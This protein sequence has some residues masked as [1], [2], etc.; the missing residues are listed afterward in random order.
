MNKK[1]LVR[2]ISK[3][4]SV[5]QKSIDEVVKSF[6]D[7]VS[8]TL[9]KGGRITLVG[10]GTFQV[11]KRKATTVVNPQTKKKMNV[12]AK[13]YAKLHFSDKVNALLNDKKEKDNK[14]KKK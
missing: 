11:R 13:K 9:K 7:V 14:K 4:A 10:F 8:K 1:E 2:E 12:P 3:K 5:P 6:T